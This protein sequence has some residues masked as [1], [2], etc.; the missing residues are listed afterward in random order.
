M[1]VLF[2]QIFAILNYKERVSFFI[3]ILIIFVNTLLE[4]LSL[5]LI[6][7]IVSLIISPDKIPNYLLINEKI[8]FYFLNRNIIPYLV[9]FM[10]I[11]YF[12]KNI[13]LGLIHIF[14]TNYIYRIQKRVSDLIFEKFI[15][16]NYMFHILN[17]RPKLILMV[18][19][20][21]NTFT[22]RVITPVLTLITELLVFIGI[23]IIVLFNKVQVIQLLVF[24]GSVLLIY[25]FYIKNKISI[26]G[27]Q[28][29]LGETN[30]IRTANETLQFIKE[31]KIFNKEIYFLNNFKTENLKSI[32]AGKKLTYFNILPRI[33]TELT[34]ITFLSVFLLLNLKQD[35]NPDNII[36]TL[37]I[38][39]AASFRLI[40][41]VNRM[42][43]SFQS[44]RF[45]MPVINPI[46]KYYKMKSNLIFKKKEKNNTNFTFQN[47]MFKNIRFNYTK[48]KL[49]TNLNFE[50]KKNQKIAIIGKSGSGKTTLI[51]LIIGFFRPK[52][53]K[54]FLNR[55]LLYRK[56]IIKL[57]EII[58]YIPQNTCLI[59][60]SVIENMLLDSS[61]KI[62]KE[63][64]AYSLKKAEL[65]KD[66]NSNNIS[67]HKTIGENGL[68]LSEGQ[69]QRLSLARALYHNREILILDEATSNLDKT[70]EKNI[71]RTLSKFKN[72]TIIMVTHSKD[73][74][75][76]FEKVY[77]VKNNKISIVKNKS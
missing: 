46:I 23:I 37:A 11:I 25:F 61:L 24:L 9:S 38:L 54:I 70:T 8:N 5:G 69:R 39:A 68:N 10:V 13:L 41:S 30:R 33:I 49:F 64:L 58:A 59:S 35:Y 67:L 22:G 45:G 52:S 31:I 42:M 21:I 76:F 12:V 47:L 34:L 60:G 72:K 71:F 3:L 32:E 28:R 26:L 29:R 57:Q 75:N 7:P 18:I 66:I 36:A 77:E 1:K 62:N 55:K 16:K 20:E 15:S 4:L 53:G 43:I 17:S 14:Q 2:K 50:I 19:S 48:K 40:P 6:V 44:L 51:N 73:N 63:K 74:L 65:I 56:N 27:E